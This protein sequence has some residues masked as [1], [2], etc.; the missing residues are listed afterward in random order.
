MAIIACGPAKAACTP[1]AGNGISALC[2]GVTAGGYGGFGFSNLNV[3]VDD[4]ASLS[5]G[6]A[7]NTGSL[8]NRGTV[9]S[10]GSAAGLN[11]GTVVNEG[12]LAGSIGIDAG[13]ATVTNRGSIAGTGIG[14]TTAGGNLTLDN[15]GTVTGFFGIFADG[16]A[17][18]N[19]GVINGVG[20]TSIDVAV[21]LSL[22]NTATGAING[23]TAAITAPLAEISNAGSITSATATAIDVVTLS[24][25]VNS[26]LV[27]GVTAA[28]HGTTA[29]IGNSGAIV[30][31]AGPA[32]DLA[33]SLTL[34]SSGLIRGSSD[35][36]KASTA[37]L[38]NSGTITGSAGR[39]IRLT[40]A[41]DI[42]NS[43]S[44]SGGSYGIESFGTVRLSNSGTI[45]G[46]FAALAISNAVI[47]NSGSILSNSVA[48]DSGNTRINNS[49][50]ITGEVIAITSNQ[51]AL[52]N[53]GTISVKASGA[54]TIYA[55]S[56]D[57]TNAGVIAAADTASLALSLGASTDTL[58]SRPGSRIIGL[59]DLGGGA[60]RVNFR[61]GNFHY[62][63]NSLAGA[64]VSS[65]APYVVS[66]SQVVTFDSTP[67][68]ATDRNLLAFISAVSSALPDADASPTSDSLVHAAPSGPKRDVR[69]AFAAITPQGPTAVYAD[70]TSVWARGFAGERDQP[71]SGALL[72]STSRFQGGLIGGDWQANSNLR[73]GA[74]IGGGAMQTS[75]DFNLATTNADIVFGG[76]FARG[77]FG[78]T[79]LD[80]MLQ[81]GHVDQRGSRLISNN[82]VAGGIETA[83]ASNSGTYAIPELALGHR[84]GLGRTG[85][86]VWT[87]TPVGR[88]R[89]LA[90]RL[91]GFS[92]SGVTA[93]ATVG[94]YTLSGLEERGELKLS[95]TTRIER[96]AWLN[97]SLRTGVVGLQRLGDPTVNLTLLGQSLPF[98]LPGANDVWGLFGG[99]G[100]DVTLGPASLFVAGEYLKLSDSSVAYSGRGG[101][102]IAF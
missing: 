17:I 15:F 28:I 35:G 84:I 57:I 19:A 31:S 34:T 100:L 94:G 41:G 12:T 64:T 101:L 92:E 95:A 66:G 8:I 44:I 61:G 97:G 26:G 65:A 86:T 56:A 78:A 16:A 82:L 3:T 83:T 102:R 40:G 87:L 45:F 68:G 43:G 30:A 7:F 93:N 10:G 98:V 49:G 79:F 67:F 77:T 62:T 70:G 2:T 46:G 90:G 13:T 36:I 11:A 6:V 21:R 37:T 81:L 91:G 5:G 69:E 76:A 72:H 51:L 18:S 33:G 75:E 63:F 25:L 27:S 54:S 29:T 85:G 58:T 50:T 38:A 53:G 9:T 42:T 32:I 88:V 1:A 22:V 47:E 80:M 24:S 52:F 4:G 59:I 89:Y 96:A 74:F 39:A 14:I 73:V 23:H 55:S 99:A 48:I 20:D 60:D 71:A